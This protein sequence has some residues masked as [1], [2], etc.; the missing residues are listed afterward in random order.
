MGYGAFDPKPFVHASSNFYSFCSLETFY[1]Y[2][3]LGQTNSQAVLGSFSMSA[4]SVSSFTWRQRNSINAHCILTLGNEPFLD[5][6]I[7]VLPVII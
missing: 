1:Q 6:L 2:D 4:A 5:G 3:S 7:P